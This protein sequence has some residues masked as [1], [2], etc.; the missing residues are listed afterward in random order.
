M[1]DAECGVPAQRDRRIGVRRRAA[2]L[3]P[4]RVEGDELRRLVEAIERK[5]DLRRLFEVV[6]EFVDAVL[7]SRII[8]VAARRLEPRHGR[9]IEVEPRVPTRNPHRLG[10]ASDWEVLDT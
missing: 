6:D 4:R 7:A 8:V 3:F 9:M 2:D 1:H 10:H 5:S